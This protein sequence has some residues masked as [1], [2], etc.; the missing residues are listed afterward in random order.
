MNKPAIVAVLV[1]VFAAAGLRAD[2]AIPGT[3]F[4]A[5]FTLENECAGSGSSASGYACSAASPL[6]SR[7]ATLAR[8]VMGMFDSTRGGMVSVFK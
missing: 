4:S 1:A 2:P 7:G 3:G 8:Y 5:N 6:L